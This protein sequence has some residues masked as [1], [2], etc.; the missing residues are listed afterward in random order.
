[1]SFNR[2]KTV[3]AKYRKYCH[4]DQEIHTCR[5]E[6]L[7]AYLLPEVDASIN[8]IACYDVLNSADLYAAWFIYN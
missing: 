3:A 5:S 4:E 1:M 6:R 8:K 2:C 7:D